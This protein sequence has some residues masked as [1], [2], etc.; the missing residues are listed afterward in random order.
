MQVGVYRSSWRAF[1]APHSA[2]RP[3]PLVH[4]PSSLMVELGSRSERCLLPRPSVH[5]WNPFR[6]GIVQTQKWGGRHFPPRRGHGDEALLA[7]GDYSPHRAQAGPQGVGAASC[8][9]RG[10]W[11][12]RS[13]GI[14]KEL[15]IR[16]N[17]AS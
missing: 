1:P 2:F 5:E 11:G 16:K 10:L 7:R 12:A 9:S 6:A 15:G 4:V 13:L 14:R 3:G 17:P 8:I